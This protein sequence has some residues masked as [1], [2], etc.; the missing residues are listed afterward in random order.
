MKKR[1]GSIG[2]VILAFSILLSACGINNKSN[3]T[4]SS[5]NGVENAFDAINDSMGDGLPEETMNNEENDLL[6]SYQFGDW[7][8]DM[9]IKK[10]SEPEGNQTVLNTKANTDEIQVLYLW[11][12]GNV[13]AATSFTESMTGYFDEYDFRPYVTILPVKE[14]VTSKGAVALMAG[15]AYQFRGNYTDSLPTAV[16]LR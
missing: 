8:N 10:M 9:M 6:E 13:P 4:A 1:I 15:G 16:A 3:E 7:S 12:D 2:I 5:N 11:E 14:G